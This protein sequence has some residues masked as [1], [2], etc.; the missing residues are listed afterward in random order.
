MNKV[1]YFLSVFLNIFILSLLQGCGS[2]DDENSLENL[3]TFVDQES[4]LEWASFWNADYTHLSYDEVLSFCDTLDASGKSDWRMPNADET[5]D[6][7]IRNTE[8]YEYTDGYNTFV[9]N[10][11]RDFSNVLNPEEGANY[12]TYEPNNIVFREVPVIDYFDNDARYYGIATIRNYNPAY[13]YDVQDADRIYSPDETSALNVF[14][15]E[16]L[17]EPQ[18]QYH[19]SFTCVR[20]THSATMIPPGTWVNVE[21]QLEIIGSGQ[22]VNGLSMVNNRH[23]RLSTVVYDGWHSVGDQY[24]DAKFTVDRDAHYISSGIPDARV[25]GVINSFAEASGTIPRALV[26]GGAKKASVSGVAGIDVIL[27]CIKNNEPQHCQEFTIEPAT[28]ENPHNTYTQTTDDSLPNILY[29]TQDA[30]GNYTLDDQNPI[31]IATGEITISLTDSAGNTAVFTVEVIGNDTDVGVLNIPDISTLYNF[32]TTIDHGMD[33]IYHGYNEGESPFLYNKTLSICNVGSA[34]I[35]G[36]TFTIE[37]AP[38][39]ASLVRSFSHNYDGSSV[40]FTAGS[41][42]NYTVD[43]EFF[44]PTEDV[45]VKFNI[46]IADNFNSLTWKDYTTFRLSQYPP[47]DVY[48]A[49]NTQPLEGYLVAPGNQLVRVQFLQYDGPQNF[50]RVPDYTGNEYSLILSTSSVLGEDTYMISTVNAPDRSMMDGFS[51][52]TAH[53]PN[54]DIENATIIPLLSGDITSYLHSGD[55]DFYILKHE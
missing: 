48:L 18:S 3:K 34:N 32:K 52:V 43:F 15:Y 10:Q 13:P 26:P 27:G 11:A 6:Y 23:I 7:V 9:S 30:L 5:L 16:Q 53:E 22:Y 47:V 44:R 45:E 8:I 1:I 25:K 4:T 20:G 39:N 41:C 54:D 24:V 35:S 50:L 19:S 33:Y 38:E 40:G 55:L 12:S 2:S 21:N 28:P 36:T 14:Y 37:V 29:V 51:D 42:E 46:T 31:T 17:Y 49:S